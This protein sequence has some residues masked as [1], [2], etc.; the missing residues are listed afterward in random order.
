MYPTSGTTIRA[1]IN[2][3]VEEASQADSFFIGERACPP[4]AVD[5]KSGT[6]PKIQI[7]AGELLSSAATERSTDGAY[8]EITRGFTADTYDCVD[9]GLEERVDDVTQAD[10]SRYF[11]Y[12][13]TAAKLTLRNMKL[14]HE[15]RVAALLMATGTFTDAANSTV[16]YTEANIATISFI[17]DVLAAI[18][19]VRNNGVNPNT[20]VLSSTVYNRVRRGTLVTNFVAGQVGK[21][22][23]VTASTLA[24]ALGDEGI[25]Q[26]LVGRARYN[27]AKKG[28]AKSMTNVWGNTYAWVGYVNPSPATLQDGGCAFTIVW[29]KEGGLWVSETYRDERRRSNMVRVR[30]NTTEKVVDAGAGTL[31]TTQ[32]S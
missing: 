7:A 14:A 8:G 18:E 4:F 26:V 16:A 32:Y 28:Q 29:N 11:N 27:S 9:R 24:Q 21:G 20:I 2:A 15:V 12:E 5:A 23:S 1:D 30:Q 19:R 22:A 25:T 13:A 31:I 3:V 17:A 6:Y 10:L